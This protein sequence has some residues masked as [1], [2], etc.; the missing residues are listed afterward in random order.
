MDECLNAIEWCNGVWCNGASLS[1]GWE[2]T[3]WI[4]ACLAHFVW[5]HDITA[6][7]FNRHGE[8]LF[9]AIKRQ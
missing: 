3:P 9:E 7:C 2:P 4:R 8:E 5:S 6:D 1:Q